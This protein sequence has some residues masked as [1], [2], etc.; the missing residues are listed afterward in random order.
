MSS[1][2]ASATV[3]ASTKENK[4][5]TTT[6]QNLRLQDH[7]HREGGI[8]GTLYRASLVLVQSL[9]GSQSPG[10]FVCHS[11][12]GRQKTQSVSPNVQ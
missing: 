4:I 7:W 10:S 9:P 8:V 2:P 6:I 1:R 5:Q 12:N 3:P 11:V